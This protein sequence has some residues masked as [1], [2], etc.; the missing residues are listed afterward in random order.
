[1]RCRHDLAVEL[2]AACAPR[3]DHDPPDVAALEEVRA[4]PRRRLRQRA[5]QG[6]GMHVSFLRIAESRSDRRTQSWL[7]P[8]QLFRRQ[9]L[10]AEPASALPDGAVAESGLV[11]DGEGELDQARA[12]MADV[13]ARQLVQLGGE[14]RVEGATGEAQLEQRARPFRFPLRSQDAGRGAGGLG[15]GNPAL[16]HRDRHAVLRQPERD[17]AAHDPAADHHHIGV[18]VLA[19]RIRHS[20]ES[21]KKATRPPSQPDHAAL[22][23]GAYSC[24]SHARGATGDSPRGLPGGRSRPAGMAKRPRPTRPHGRRTRRRGGP[25]PCRPG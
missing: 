11:F 2:H 25:S 18:R 8:S 24:R 1:M 6:A 16:D 7:E 14:G 12:D 3:F 9:D 20:V 15:A 5:R 22:T 13:D 17:R 4:H 21:I 23:G 10:G 19:A